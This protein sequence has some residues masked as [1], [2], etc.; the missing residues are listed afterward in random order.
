VPALTAATL[1]QVVMPGDAGVRDTVYIT[2]GLALPTGWASYSTLS[3]APTLQAL[4]GGQTLIELMLPWNGQAVGFS[5]SEQPNGVDPRFIPSGAVAAPF[6][7][8]VL[9]G[10]P[11]ANFGILNGYT[12]PV[13]GQPTIAV[14]SDD[15]G[16]LSIW[17]L[18]ASS[19]PVADAG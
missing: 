2:A 12:D 1:A 16:V 8:N 3:T 19:G 7:P 11:A 15:G 13:T 5:L 18:S 4:P 14:A 6:L 9:G 17:Q 10:F